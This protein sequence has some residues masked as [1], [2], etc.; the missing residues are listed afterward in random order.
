MKEAESLPR[1]AAV[2]ARAPAGAPCVRAKQQGREAYVRLRLGCPPAARPLMGMRQSHGCPV[3]P[4][5]GGEA[6]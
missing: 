5:G 4:V 2:L 3:S 1:S 6:R